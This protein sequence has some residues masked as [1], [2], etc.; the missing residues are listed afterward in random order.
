[1]KTDTA[2]IL[3][4]GEGR[5]LD[6]PDNPKP[7][8]RV[9]SK[10][11]IV[12]IIEQ[13][14]ENGVNNIYVVV[15]HRADEIRHEL[16]GNSNIT[17]A[18]H[19]VEQTDSTEGALL[20]SIFSITDFIDKPCYVSMSDL[21]IEKNPY[22]LFHAIEDHDPKTIYTLIGVKKSNLS[23]SG[24]LSRVCID[25]KCVTKIGT[26]L[27]TY[28][29][30]E[31][32]VYG[33]TPEIL[34]DMKKSAKIHN[35]KTL[36]E[37]LQHYAKEKHVRP[38]LL[39]EGEWFDVNTPA[40][41]VRA[42]IFL[43][44]REQVGGIKKVKEDLRDLTSF[45]HF[46]RDKRMTTDIFFE[47]GIVRKINELQIIPE[48][49]ASSPHFIITDSK[50]DRLYGEEVLKGFLDAGFDV[51]KF[52]IEE[53][54][55]SKNIKEF[56]LLADKIF[57]YGIDKESIIISL[58]GGVVN[59]I[60]GVLASTL[61]RGV[62]LIH[63]ATSA[64]SQFDAS[65]DFKQAIN[66]TAGKNLIGSYYPASKI[67]I[68][69]EVLTTLDERHIRNGLAESI[70]HALV[71]DKEFVTYL[72]ENANNFKDIDFLETVGRKTIELKV[73]LLSGDVN[74]DRNEMLPQY[75]H[76]VGHAVEHLSSYKLL[77]GEAI[78]IGMCVSAEIARLLG[79]C[80]DNVVEL[81][82]EIAKRYKLPTKVPTKMSPEDVCDMI[83]YDKHHHKGLPHMALVSGIG[84]VWHD[85]SVYGVPIDYE[86]LSSA[87]VINQK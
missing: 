38:V 34:T 61:Y 64:M 28:D 70:K 66:S 29:G 52:V 56:T 63:I 54:E 69:P 23:R 25:G 74:D 81:H 84:S 60:A 14:Q 42:N 4:A 2:V 47:R 53:G 24:A 40:T 50:V 68:D 3:A 5:R 41:H 11:M 49:A 15:G 12:R 62:G 39:E 21:V 43:R 67:I 77:H 44:A 65:L 10:P 78:S 73:P 16:T 19:F 58:G 27:D 8:V 57:S 59:N 75:G 48:S 76:S 20:K 37:L 87:I 71:Q 45:S 22:T 6:R 79:F 55:S 7:L 9:G 35:I 86:V 17:A 31:V 26:D 46:Y 30:L 51:K 1:M 80:E 82:Y 18:L 83:R 36:G 33:F 32:G 13:L 72:N 85:G